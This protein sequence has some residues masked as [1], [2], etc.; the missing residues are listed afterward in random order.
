MAT[1]DVFRIIFIKFSSSDDDAELK[2]IKFLRME[3]TFS[4]RFLEIH[5]RNFPIAFGKIISFY[6]REIASKACFIQLI[7]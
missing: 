4:S 3:R 7:S 5:C 2:K 1:H 6:I